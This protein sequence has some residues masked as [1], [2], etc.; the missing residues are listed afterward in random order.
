M[1][2]FGA[3]NAG[4]ALTNFDDLMICGAGN[5]TQV[6]DNGGRGCLLGFS[7]DILVINQSVN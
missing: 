6:C 3:G 1:G 7:Y 5:C 2:I 4:A